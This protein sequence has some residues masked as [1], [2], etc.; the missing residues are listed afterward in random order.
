MFNDLD[1][2][3]H[4][5]LR[6]SIVS[7]LITVE[8]TNFSFI[9]DST[10]AA[11]G[12]ISIQINKLHEAG[13]ITVEKTFKNNYPNTIISITDKGRKAFEDYVKNLQKYIYPDK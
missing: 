12:N 10:K 8:E 11:A 9:R 4:S 7:I 6:L 3:L 13:Y 2:I 1:P 5:Q